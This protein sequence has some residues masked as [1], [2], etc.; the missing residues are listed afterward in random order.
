MAESEAM[1]RKRCLTNVLVF[2]KSIKCPEDACSGS[3]LIKDSRVKRWE[4]EEALQRCAC[5]DWKLELFQA[6]RGGS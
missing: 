2:V 1:G 6:P 5:F 4:T 3:E